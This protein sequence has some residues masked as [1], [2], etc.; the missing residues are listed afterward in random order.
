M[1]T[2]FKVMILLIVLQDRFINFQSLLAKD[3][4]FQHLLVGHKYKQPI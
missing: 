4:G 2:K 3:K 1:T